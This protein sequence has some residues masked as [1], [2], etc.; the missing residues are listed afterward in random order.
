MICVDLQPLSY[1][2]DEGFKMLMKAS[3]PRYVI[4]SRATFRNELIPKLY[5]EILSSL[6]SMIKEHIC[7]TT[8]LLVSQ[9]MPGRLPMLQVI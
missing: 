7:V 5:N 6:K 1:I 4:P 3:E 2:E 8:P 9:Q